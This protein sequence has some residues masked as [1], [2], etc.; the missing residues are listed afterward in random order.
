M[1][2]FKGPLYYAPLV[3]KIQEMD[4]VIEDMKMKIEKLKIAFYEK[5]IEE[6][7]ECPDVIESDIAMMEIM[8]EVYVSAVAE[9]EPEGDT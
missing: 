4:T 5:E 1:A 6:E 7:E 9:E 2:K 3:Q 8:R